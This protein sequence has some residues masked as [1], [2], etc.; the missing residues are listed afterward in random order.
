MAK[1]INAVNTKDTLARFNRHASL[2]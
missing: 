1:E 2:S